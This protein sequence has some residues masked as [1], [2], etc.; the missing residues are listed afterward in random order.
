MQL[1]VLTLSSTI[2]IILIFMIEQVTIN[3]FKS[4]RHL[5]FDLKPLNILIGANGAGKS[6]FLSFFKLV[7]S[8]V[9]TKF[10][11]YNREY[12]QN[13]DSLLYFGRKRSS[14]MK[15]EIR[16]GKFYKIAF[17]I[18]PQEN[19][20][21][22]LIQGSRED[23]G[24]ISENK[25]FDN[26]INEG[27]H[28]LDAA[29]RSGD[30]ERELINGLIYHFDDTSKSSPM[31]KISKVND[32]RF[33]RE[34]GENLAAFLY[35]LQE[36]HFNSFKLIEQNIRS[37]A[38]FFDRFDLQSDRL[39]EGEIE[40][41][42]REKA[43][44]DYFNAYSLSDGTLRYIALTTLLLQPDLPKTIIIDEPELG[45][46]PFAINKL[47][48]MIKQAVIRGS[49]VIVSTQSVDLVNNFEPEDVIAVDR[50]NDQ[51]VFQRLKSDE[52]KEWLEDYTLGELWTKNLVG[53]MP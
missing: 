25:I 21:F 10:W 36:K 17:T 32:N 34:N 42:W 20:N 14:E 15:G 6:N 28:I 4:I 3:N 24:F 29:F 49:Q 23:L 50:K 47:A 7:Y 45:L 18:V 1:L 13:I 12:N 8:T 2:S 11:E 38:P 51:S 9:G 53:A 44:D 41:R 19:S 46:H 35:Y 5:E 22:G 26:S 40:L 37:V 16:F 48:A 39:N 27:E 33:L 43:S 31:K 52:L 30:V